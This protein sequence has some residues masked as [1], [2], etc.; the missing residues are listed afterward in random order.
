MQINRRE[1]MLAGTAIG[2]AL[3]AGVI[4]P[5]A[6]VLSDD[7][8]ESSAA[9]GAQLSTFPRLRVASISELSSGEPQFF[10][11]P[12][13][14]QS[15][16][17]VKLRDRAV[18]GIGEQ[19]D[20]VAFSNACTHMGCPVTDYQPAHNMLGPCACHFTTFDLSR[21]G[22]VVLGQATEKLPRV[23]LETDGDS[24]YAIGVFRLIYGHQNNLGGIT[25]VAAS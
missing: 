22:Q 24:L 23:L 25:A 8:A 15:N 16:I 14:G 21:D 7:D 1:M 9:T 4:V 3:A 6:F 5:V 20:I 18:G 19:H 13:A 11:Y 17:V 10:D 12:L 2:A